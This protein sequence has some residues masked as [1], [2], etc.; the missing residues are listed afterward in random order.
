M[1]TNN[2]NSNAELFPSR[3]YWKSFLLV[4]GG[5]VSVLLAGLIF[6]YSDP[7][8]IAFLILPYFVFSLPIVMGEAL[9][10]LI[11]SKIQDFP[12]IFVVFI[13]HTAV[14]LSL[15]IFLTLGVVVLLGDEMGFASLAVAVAG[16]LAAAVFLLYSLVRMTVWYVLRRKNPDKSSALTLMKW[17]FTHALK[18]YIILFVM[19]IIIQIAVD[20]LD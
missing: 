5:G 8:D 3:D 17:F 19:A 18:A 7:E 2:S 4:L 9:L 20:F 6:A 10:A 16:V 1:E 13:L 11:F 15:L 12:G 14:Y